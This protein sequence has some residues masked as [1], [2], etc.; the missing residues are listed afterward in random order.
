[1]KQIQVQL[2]DTDSVVDAELSF[3]DKEYVVRLAPYEF[4]GELSQVEIHKTKNSISYGLG[5]PRGISKDYRPRTYWAYIEGQPATL[6]DARASVAHEGNSLMGGLQ[7][8]LAGRRLV[9][10]AHLDSDEHPVNGV[11][12]AL[13]WR[14]GLVGTSGPAS[15]YQ[16]L[17]SRYWPG[18]RSV[19]GPAPARARR[20]FPVIA[21]GSGL[22]VAVTAHVDFADA[23]FAGVVG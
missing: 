8:I 15:W 2:P 19:R 16:I 20:L 11:R 9:Y 21:G 14:I 7:Q 17:R 22:V 5:N 4:L 13:D 1:M 3:T 12:F 18:G 6:L 23:D 10:G